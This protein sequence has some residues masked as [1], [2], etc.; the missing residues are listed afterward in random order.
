MVGELLSGW[1]DLQTQ[2]WGARPQSQGQAR[3]GHG[4]RA[5]FSITG[6]DTWGEL[7]PAAYHKLLPRPN[8]IGKSLRRCD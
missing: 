4:G 5:S 7:I 6:S 2:Q 3:P 1:R 8:L